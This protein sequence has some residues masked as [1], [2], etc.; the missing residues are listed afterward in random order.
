MGQTVCPIISAEDRAHLDA[1]I[2]DRSRPLKHVQRAKIITHSADRLPAAEVA[3][4]R[5]GA[6]SVQ[7]SS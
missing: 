2:G 5:Q 6:Q 7:T 1:I 3:A 4:D